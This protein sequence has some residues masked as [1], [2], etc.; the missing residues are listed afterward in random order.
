MTEQAINGLRISGDGSKVFCLTWKSIQA[1]SILTGE[2]MGEAILGGDSPSLDPLHGNDSRIWVC[3]KGSP[4]QGWDFG[5]PSSPPI[6]LSNTFLYRPR[7]NFVSGTGQ[8]TGPPMIKDAVTRKVVFQ[9]PRRFVDNVE[10]QWD[11]QYLVAGHRSGGV[12]ILDFSHV[13]P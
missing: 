9:L 3:F 7:L 1:W 8:G 2:A 12:L 4:T 11:G 13:L 5:D 6:L 10:I